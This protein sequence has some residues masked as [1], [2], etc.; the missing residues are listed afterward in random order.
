MKLDNM[1]KK[2]RIV[3]R[4]QSHSAVRAS[5]PE[6]PEG[7]L[8]KCNKCG[9]AIIAE[10]VKQGYYICPKCGGYFRVHA[11]RRIQM[12]I[13]EGT[14]EEWNQDLIGGNPVNYKGY[15]EKVQ[16]LQEKTGLKEAVVTGKGKINGR[17]TVI[18]VCDGRFLMAS[19]GWAVGEK[20]TR[21]V[22]RATEEKL[23]IIIFACSGGARMQEGI[24]SLMQMAKTSAAL[25]RHS[26]AGLLYVSVLTEPTTGGVTASFAMLGD[27]ILAEPGALIGFAGP[28][29]IEQTLRQKLPKGFQRAEFLVEHGFVDDIVRRENLKE[30]L[31]KIL[32][33]HAVSWKTENRIRTDAAELHHADYP[34]SDS[35]NLT[36][37]KCDSDRGD[38]NP[39]GINPYLTAWDRVQISR[40]IDRPSGSDYIE[41]LFTDFMEFHGD[42]NYGDD[43]AIIGGIAKFHG[44][45]VTV[46]VQEKG[47]NTKENIAHNFGM[48]MPEGYRKAL[49]L[50]KQAEKFHRPVICFVDTPG[51]FCGIEAEERG[52][53]EAIARNLWEL[54]GLKTPVLSIVTGEG[55]SGGAL[56]LAA[57]D[58]VWM[59]ENSIY[60]ILSPEGFA[61]I[62]WKDSTKAKEA[63][64]VM[65]LT[66]GDLYEKGIIEQVIPEP[67]NLTPE[68]MWQV[69][70]RL[71]DK[72]CTFLQKYTSLSEEELLETRYARF[73][74]F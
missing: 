21:A 39:A 22:E 26:K 28:R 59:L 58:Q 46:I 16:A 23:P 17:D 45:P 66:A 10:D 52:Q 4:I 8:R 56:V 57:G 48:P 14:F 36:N 54:A 29:V 32:E 61:S 13:D 9:A 35:E 50:M 63:A 6:V 20:I 64:G 42:R 3:S 43:K 18:A 72:I 51:A 11:Y 44:K 41:A 65:K 7:L 69:A 31:G 1:F 15:P 55:G 49:R 38:S 67:E 71:N 40:K 19:M 47:T 62:L 2:T 74:K 70:E 53:G 33:I 73:R 24:T 5:R 34:G 27:I 12:V 60:S 37:D 30:T 25:E 68:S